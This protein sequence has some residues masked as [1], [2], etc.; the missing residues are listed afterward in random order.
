MEVSICQLD[1]YTAFTVSGKGSGYGYELVKILGARDRFAGFPRRVGVFD[2]ILSGIC[3]ANPNVP[4]RSSC[5]T[6][7]TN[8]GWNR[9]LSTLAFF[10]LLLLHPSHAVSPGSRRF[11]RASFID[12]S[13]GD[14]PPPPKSN[15]ILL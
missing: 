12:R 15:P 7:Q 14:P 4:V 13:A 10:L 5:Y 9:A 6:L 3:I 2:L 1:L 8:R 11:S